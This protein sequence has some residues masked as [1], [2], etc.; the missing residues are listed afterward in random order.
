MPIELIIV[1][2][3][4]ESFSGSVDQ[5][6]LPGSEGD[7]GV[8]EQHERFLAP[9]RHGA[10]E[11]KTGQSSDWAA[12]SSGFADVSAERVTV[13][14]DYCALAHDIDVAMAK[15]EQREAEAELA[16]L[17]ETNEHEARRAQLQDVLLHASIQLHVAEK[18][19]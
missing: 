10:I 11:I 4:G 7:F 18:R 12:V 1:T 9:L 8:L 17:P 13:L 6:V 2:P 14:A 16:A 15:E 19:I 5:V 3:E